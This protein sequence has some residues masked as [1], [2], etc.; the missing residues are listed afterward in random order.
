MVRKREAEDREQRKMR[1]RLSVEK[2]LS[3]EIPEEVKQI[4]PCS[5]L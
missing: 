3:G 5:R 4:W 2:K 1:M